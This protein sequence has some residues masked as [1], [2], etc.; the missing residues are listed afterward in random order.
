MNYYLRNWHNYIIMI[1]EQAV[2]YEKIVEIK[3]GIFAIL[4]MIWRWHDE[5]DSKV[6]LEGALRTYRLRRY[7]L[8]SWTPTYIRQNLI[9]QFV[10][11]CL[12]V[13]QQFGC[14]IFIY[15]LFNFDLRFHIQFVSSTNLAFEDI[16]Y[17]ISISFSILFL[18]GSK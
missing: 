5:M 11:L 9:L 3:I 12:F 14:H 6:E 15:K 16:V 4:L 13:L 2:K 8:R 17:S 18:R 7:L 10:L 1:G